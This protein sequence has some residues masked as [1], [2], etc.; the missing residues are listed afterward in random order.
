MGFTKLFLWIFILNTGNISLVQTPF[1]KISDDSY[2]IKGMGLYIGFAILLV[3]AIFISVFSY[4]KQRSFR[5]KFEAYLLKEGNKM[6]SEN[7][8]I[9]N[10]QRKDIDVPDEIATGIL[11]Q[12][13]EFEKSITFTDSTIT[14]NSLAKAFQ[15]NSNYLSK[16]IN[17]YRGMSFPVYMNDLRIT[18]ALEKIKSDASFRKYTI[19]AIA[20][21]SGIKSAET[22]SKFFFKKTGVYPSCFIKQMNE[23]EKDV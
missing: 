2:Y 11:R 5:K 6:I 10:N 20:N 19:K 17:F 12:L 13:E 4:L 3:I 21:E 1:F 15:T 18:Y 7:D 8:H 22:F 9:A 16:I 14:L 23:F